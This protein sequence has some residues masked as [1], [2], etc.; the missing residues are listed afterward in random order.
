MDKVKQKATQQ[1]V[2]EIDGDE[3]ATRLCEAINGFPRP[4]GAT[5]NQAM[6]ALDEI[7]RNMWRCGANAAMRYWAECIANS[8]KTN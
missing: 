4:A 7:D 6:E 5:G 1:L 8:Q 3:L 2:G